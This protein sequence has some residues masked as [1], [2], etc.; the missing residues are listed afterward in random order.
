MI[1]W[2][3]TKDQINDI[4]VKN[5]YKILVEEKKVYTEE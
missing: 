2:R 4:D 3:F 1:N 5:Y